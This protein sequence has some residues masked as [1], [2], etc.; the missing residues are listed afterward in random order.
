MVYTSEKEEVS[1]L[2]QMEEKMYRSRKNQVRFFLM[3][4]VLVA[5]IIGAATYVFAYHI[6]RFTLEMELLGDEE[7]ILEYGETY[8]D[9]GARAQFYGTH[10]FQEGLDVDV[11]TEGEVDTSRLGTYEI[12]YAASH[13]RWQ[14]E[15]S[16]TVRIVDTVAPAIWLAETPGSY[17]IPGQ[18]YQ[19]DGYMARDNYDGDLTAHV[20]KTVLSD[21]IIYA[22]EDSSGNR[23]EVTREIVYYD[24]IPPEITLSGDASITL[25]YGK[26][27]VEPGYSAYDN[28]EGDITDRV[29]VSGSVNSAQAGTYTI[30]YTVRDRYGNTDTQVRTVKVK[31]RVLPRPQQSEV[32]PAGKVIYL[33]FDDGPSAHT[34]RLL[35]ILKKYNVKATFFVINTGYTHLLDDMV[36]QGHS[37]GAHTYSHNYNTIYASEEAYFNDLNRILSVISSKAGV[38]TKLIRFPGGSSNTVSR[39]NPGIMSR[40]ANEVVDKGYRYFDWNVSSGDAG[41]ATTS[42]KVYENV[43]NGIKGRSVAV[44]LQHDTKGFSVDAVEQIIIWGLENGY[45]FLPLGSTSPTAAHGLNN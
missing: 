31:A 24:P 41:G 2:E 9:A 5:L 28:C 44:V 17:V 30:T 3:I 10:L 26:E 36:A 32:T 19:E 35:G 27:Y 45:T 7:I 34:E 39:F 43:I 38:N 21:R 15:M 25:A 13:E 16:R 1:T 18:S 6:N 4:P 11:V 33:T 42:K 29:Q 22:V 8:V 20:E 23:A 14:A 12:R 37:I 40:L